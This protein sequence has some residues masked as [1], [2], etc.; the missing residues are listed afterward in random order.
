[1]WV[2][3]KHAEPVDRGLRM[4]SVEHRCPGRGVPHLVKGEEEEKGGKKL[5]NFLNTAPETQKKRHSREK[6]VAEGGKAGFTL[7][8]TNDI[9]FVA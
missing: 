5:P 6:Y 9:V 7:A 2:E 3:K 4:E 8:S 1:M